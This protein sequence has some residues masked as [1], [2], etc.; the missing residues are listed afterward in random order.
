MIS[1]PQWYCEIYSKRVENGLFYGLIFLSKGAPLYSKWVENGLFYGM[2]FLPKDAPLVASRGSLSGALIPLL[3]A[4]KGIRAR[5]SG[6]LDATKGAS[7]ADKKV[8]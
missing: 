1:F 7:F 3:A 4:D 2:I 6:R 8:L 5:H